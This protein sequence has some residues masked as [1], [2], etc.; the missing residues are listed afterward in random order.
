MIKCAIGLL[1]CSV[2]FAQYGGPGILTGMGNI[3]D[4]GGRPSGI[5]FFA[6]VTGSLDEGLLPVSVDQKGQLI[7]ENNLYSVVMNVGAYGRKNFK[8]TSIGL[9]FIANYRHYGHNQYYDGVDTALALTV[10]RQV[11]KRTIIAFNNV[12]GTLSQ[13]FGALYG[14]VSTPG[15]LVGVPVNNIFDNRTYFWQTGGQVAYQKSARWTFTA[16]GTG[17]FIRPQSK[18]LVGVDGYGGQAGATYQATRRTAVYFSYNNYHF[19]YPGA[20]GDSDANIVLVGLSRALSRRWTAQLGVGASR[21]STVGVGQIAADP[22]T[23]ALFGI[24]SVTKAFSAH[25]INPAV[26]ASLS[27]KFRR[28]GLNVT[29]IEMPNPGNGVYLTSNMRSGSAV[30][31]YVA[32]RRTSTSLGITFS[33]MESIGQKEL[34]RYRYFYGSAA[35]T[36]RIAESLHAVASVGARNLDINN[37]GKFSRFG[38]SITLGLMFSPGERP[39]AFW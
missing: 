32:N 10:E 15:D 21:T 3:G 24:T 5:R 4:R 2:A 8:H 36:Y 34:G 13:G 7:E 18:V 27:G 29:Y 6:G 23:A 25:T 22:V 14:Y 30:Y 16:G 1:A 17:F 9:N 33:D 19:D 28:S 11:T 31:S 20:F 35:L 12:G 39:L 38:Y 26:Q 37:E